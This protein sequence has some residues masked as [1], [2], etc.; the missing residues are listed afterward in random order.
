MDV[1]YACTTGGPERGRQ[2]GDGPFG[3]A[4]SASRSQAGRQWSFRGA[5]AVSSR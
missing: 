2:L 1:A 3:S 4:D 5:T